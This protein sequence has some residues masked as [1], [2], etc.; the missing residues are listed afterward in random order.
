MDKKLKM[1]QLQLNKAKLDHQIAKDNGREDE[2]V[3]GRGMVLDRNAL[4][5]QILGKNRTEEK[6]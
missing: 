5:D 3:D 1:I 2:P 6:K 4:L